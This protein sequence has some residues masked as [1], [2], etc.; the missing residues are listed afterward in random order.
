[1]IICVLIYYNYIY[2]YM[3]MGKDRSLI[4]FIENGSLGIPGADTPIV[5]VVTIDM[6]AID[7]EADVESREFVKALRSAYYDDEFI[8][9][10]PSFKKQLDSE[11]ESMRIL[12]KMRKADETAHDALIHAIEQNSSNASLYRSLSDMQKTILSITEKIDTCKTNLITLLKNYQLEINFKEDN[13]TNNDSEDTP[14]DTYRGTKEFIESMKSDME[15]NDMESSPEES[16][17]E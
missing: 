11:I 8:R 2:K 5:D 14:S 1:M 9:E 10:N 17:E 15:L 6:D 13:Y 16:T 4:D 3:N 12:I 7:N